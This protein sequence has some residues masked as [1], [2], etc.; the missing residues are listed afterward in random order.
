MGAGHAR[1]AMERDTSRNKIGSSEGYPKSGGAKASRFLLL[2]LYVRFDISS[3]GGGAVNPEKQVKWLHGVVRSPPF[4]FDARLEAGGLI[5]SLQQG[6]QLSLPVSRPMPRIGA[7]CHELK[8]KDR[9]K[10]WRIIY[11]TD[12]RYILILDVFLKKTRKTPDS[13][14]NNCQKRLSSY[15]SKTGGQ[16]ERGHH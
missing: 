14:I 1:R 5:G 7:R 11:R 8:I 10:E 13:V 6:N 4:S 15:D 12:P 2:A 16:R 9:K 3:E